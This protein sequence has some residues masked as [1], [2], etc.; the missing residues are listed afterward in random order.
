MH[1]IE[2]YHKKKIIIMYEFIYCIL[3][4]IIYI[5]NSSLNTRQNEDSNQ[6]YK[7]YFPTTADSILQFKKNLF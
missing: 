3:Y 6:L 4:F 7:K 5:Y 2:K 1:I